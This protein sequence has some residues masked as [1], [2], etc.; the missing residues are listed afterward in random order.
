MPNQRTQ[1]TALMRIL[2]W[3]MAAMVLTMLGIGVT[4]VVSLGRLPRSRVDPSAA[5]RRHSGPGRRPLRGSPTESAS[6]IPT[7]DVAPGASGGIGVGIHDVRLDVR[8]AA[9]RLEHAVGGAVPDRAVRLRPLAVHPAARRPCC[10]RSCGRT[11]TVLAYLLFLTIL[12]HFGAI[13]FHTLIVR[14]GIAVPD[15]AMEHWPT[16]GKHSMTLTGE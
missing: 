13:L 14:D 12:A 9:G 7:H 3:T 16:K 15:G 5:G 6:A 1:F 8:P 4:M 11:H 2:H 10:T